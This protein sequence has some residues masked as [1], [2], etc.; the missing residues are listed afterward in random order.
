MEWIPSWGSLW[1]AF[2]SVSAPLFAPAFPLDRN[3]SWLKF[4]R[5]VGGPIPL[6][7]AVQ[8][9]SPL[10]WVYMDGSMA[11]AIYVAEDGLI[12]ISGMGGPWSCGDL[13]LEHRVI[14]EQ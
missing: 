13:K 1:V 2:P 8:V 9:L 14:L 4:F 11:P 7:G 12:Y 6:L 10:C 3:N 5:W